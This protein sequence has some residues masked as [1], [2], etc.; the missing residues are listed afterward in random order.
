[1]NKTEAFQILKTEITKDER[2][3]KNAYRER[4]AVTNPED[5]PEGFKELRTAYEEACRYARQEDDGEQ[6]KPRDTSPSGLWVEKAAEIYGNIR[7]RRDIELW[8]ELFTEDIFLSLED[9]ENCR[10]KL[11][12]FLMDHFKLPTEVWQ[13]LDKRLNIVGDAGTLREK[14]PA[15][16]MRYIVSKCE[17]GEDVDF[18]LF[19]GADDGEYDLFLQYYERCWQDLQEDRLEEAGENLEKADAL[20][21]RHPVLEIC[22]ARYLYKKNQMDQALELMRKLHAQ[23]PE[24]AMVCYNL[25]EM[26][27][28]MGE[29]GE[30]GFREQSAE[31]YEK[32]KA[33]SDGYYMA[34]VRLTEW[35]YEKGRFRDAKKCA[36]KVLAAGGDEAFMKMLG[37]VNAKI[38]EELEAEYRENGRW[39]PALELCWCYL[40]DGRISA[41]I[42]LAVRIE[43][44]L[45]EEKRAE[46]CGL[47]AKLYVE[48]AEYEDSVF[49]THSWQEEL[50]KKLAMEG[51]GEER[52]KDLNRLMQAHLIR[53]QCY[54]NLGFLDEEN[55]RLAI[56]EGK[57]ILTGTSEDIG[58][59]LEMSQVY[60]EM[61]EYE[62]GLE[63]THKLMD[64]YQV[65]AA[66]AAA[67]EI[68]RRQLNP[69]GVLRTGGQCI[70]YFPA[71]QKAYEYMAKVYL[72]LDYR[73]E[74]KKLCDDAQ[75][76]GIKSVI[77][78]AYLYQLDHKLLSIDDLNKKLK[79]FR[80][81]FRRPLEEG[82]IEYYEKGLP[83][84]TEYVYHYPD[85]Y[86]LIERGI[87][88]RAGHHYEEAKADL[89][90]ALSLDPSN[91]YALNAMS[92]VC[93]YMG[94]YE[95]A[96]FYIKKAILY[97]DEK[98]SRVIYADMGILY[99]LLGDP[100]MALAG[101]RQYEQ[102]LGNKKEY[103]YLKMMAEFHARLGK[104][105]NA[106]ELYR[107]V[108]EGN[109]RELA[110]YYE[111]LATM[112]IE[113]GMED[114]A[115][116]ILERW[117]RGTGI[118]RFAGLW[119]RMKRKFQPLGEEAL[120]EAAEAA[121]YFQNQ[122]WTELVFGQPAAAVRA[123][124]R[125]AGCVAEVSRAISRNSPVSRKDQAPGGGSASRKDQ[126][127][128]YE[129]EE[130]RL[131]DAVF[132]AILCGGEDRGREYSRR[133]RRWL[134]G[135][136]SSGKAPYYNRPKA[137]AHI[138][139]LAGY[140]TETEDRL[141]E[142]LDGA[143]GCEICH[144][145][146]NPVCKELEGMR[147]LLLLRQRKRGEAAARIKRN[148]EIQPLDEFMRAVRHV[149]FQD[150]V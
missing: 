72:D 138:Q 113:S 129:N 115:R 88:H 64:E 66:N 131:C 104:V 119:G 23:H 6:E 100:E 135:Q 71:Y 13:L 91:A 117:A 4:L 112:Y 102:E 80:I 11:L 3:I 50:E 84:L 56:E 48:Q 143:E 57:K 86:M 59:L 132:A 133:L 73:E 136:G 17:R 103:W 94:N 150:E 2:A 16:F 28:R 21:I 87:F 47:L 90:K 101:Y 147:V 49:M 123:F 39:E 60:T 99:A 58:I 140:Y 127:A 26:L 121:I 130:T 7:S 24:D 75:K 74:L 53:V 19:E 37:K 67:M 18:F 15:D 126:A 83:V 35:Y 43:K 29:S 31:I 76:G 109:G 62:L 89:E 124:D 36:E 46:Y 38:E 82:R 25:A 93:K 63:L 12:S 134:D 5:D 61:E 65:I 142:I 108:Y 79:N 14:F 40:Q 27:W 120:R 20:D 78:D 144:S 141:Q 34:N 81:N 97:M 128:Q 54:H 111:H 98:M 118:E 42:R 44:Q 145:C 9:E 114:R 45:P 106:E 95:K 69:G 1:M 55:F 22:R 148:L 107:K 70:Q 92:V 110:K 96:L 122:G 146:T 10:V 77:L 68:Y 52:E 105:E 116:Q 149:A 125:M 85:S 30:G 8:K 139:F 32:L 33:Q 41:G 137:L 51:E